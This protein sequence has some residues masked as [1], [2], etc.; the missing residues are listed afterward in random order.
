[1]QW[2]AAWLLQLCYGTDQHTEPGAGGLLLLFCSLTSSSAVSMCAVLEVRCSDVF[3]RSC[4][5]SE[6]Q[7]VHGLPLLLGQLM[8]DVC[9]SSWLLWGLCLL[10]LSSYLLKCLQKTNI[11]PGRDEHMLLCCIVHYGPGE[12]GRGGGG[13]EGREGSSAP[14]CAWSAG[15]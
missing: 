15:R 14:C 13:G 8:G 5:T 6:Q 7:L 4:Q 9:L 3:F 2:R 12:W 10:S 1:M 11:V